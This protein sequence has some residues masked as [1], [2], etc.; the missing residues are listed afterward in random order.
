ILDISMPGMDGLE[1]AKQL[2]VSKSKTKIIL[3][4]MPLYNF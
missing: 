1:I 4:T 2:G 3:L